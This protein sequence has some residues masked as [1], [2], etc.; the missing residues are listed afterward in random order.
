MSEP[1][2][3]RILTQYNLLIAWNG[4]LRP[5]KRLDT[6]IEENVAVEAQK[7]ERPER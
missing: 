6:T 4:K 7:H 2:E 3:K 1:Q 5:V